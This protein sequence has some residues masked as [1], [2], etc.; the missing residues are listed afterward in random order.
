MPVLNPEI[1]SEG[2]L[3]FS[4]MLLPDQFVVLP[5]CMFVCN[6]LLTEV[7]YCNIFISVF[8]Q[9][10]FYIKF[11]N[12]LILLVYIYIYNMKRKKQILILIKER[13]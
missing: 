11:K 6:M 1:A 13:C 9:D 5:L 3:W 12:F 8:Y 2:A 4:N 10:K 7:S